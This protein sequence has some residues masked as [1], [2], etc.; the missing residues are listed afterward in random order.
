MLVNFIT[1]VQMPDRSNL[2]EKELFCLSFRDK[3][4]HGGEGMVEL[5]VVSVYERSSTHL[6]RAGI[7]QDEKQDQVVTFKVHASACLLPKSYIL[8]VPQFP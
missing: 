8:K 3:D 1:V 6:S 5:L 7:R 4:H 2:K